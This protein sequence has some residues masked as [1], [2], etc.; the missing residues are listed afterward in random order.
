MEFSTL[1]AQEAET[2]VGLLQKLTDPQWLQNTG[3][4]WGGKLLTVLAIF[5]IGKWVA[6]MA[7]RVLQKICRRSKLDETLVTFTG[8]IAYGLLMVFVVLAALDKM[9]VNVTSV[10]AILAAAGF[11]VGM[12][13][14]GSLGNFAAGVML[15][16]FKP[17]GVGDLVEAGGTFGV[18]DELGL[19]ATTFTTP[20]GKRVIVPNGTI[21][22]AN[23]T[24]LS[25]NGRIRVEMTMGI[26]YEDDIRKAKE[27]MMGVLERDPQVLKDP[28]PSVAVSELAD[29]SVNFAVFP[30]CHPDHYWDVRF[31]THERIKLALDDAGISIPFPQQDVHMHQA[32]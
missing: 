12:A 22:A 4:T 17:I 7:S 19:F 26:G 21:T 14:Q 25:A 5:V 11:A 27:I 20:D 23:I 32:A 18:V 16:F 2:T 8:N 31:N 15:V 6:G 1:L 29:S 9:G 13:L 3:V 24:N 28:A 10:A 30:W